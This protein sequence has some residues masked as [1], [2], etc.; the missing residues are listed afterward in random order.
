LSLAAHGSEPCAAALLRYAHEVALLVAAG[1]DRGLTEDNGFSVEAW[2]RQEIVQPDVL[3]A[4]LAL[5]A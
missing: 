2:A 3:R 1:A 4:V 5:L